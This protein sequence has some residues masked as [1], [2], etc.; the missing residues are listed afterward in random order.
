MS[1]P[2][3]SLY[4]NGEWVDTGENYEIRSPATEELVATVAKG[5]VAQ[6][7]QAVA[8]AKAAHEEGTWRRTP[9]AQRAALLNDVAGRLGGR[10]DELAA[11]QTRENGATIRITGALHI[12]LSIAQMQYLADQAAT[13]EFETAGPEIGPVPAEGLVRREPLGVVAAIVPWN[14]PLLVI[15]WK[16]APALAAGN[17]V[18]L[19]PDEHAPLVALELAKEFE[20]AG[21]PP[22]VLNVVT[23]DGEPTGAHLSG[24]PDVRKVAFTG[25]TAV[26][27]SILRQSADT[28]K[29]VTLELGGKGPNIILDSA[30]LDTAIDGSL[31][32]AL[33]NNGQACEA[34]TRL[35]IP[36]SKRDEIVSRLVERARTLKVGDPLDPATGVGPII[37]K[38]QHQRILDYFAIAETEGA[39]AVIGGGVPTGPGFDKGYWIEPTIFVGVTNDARIAREEVFGPVLVVLTY[40]SVEEAIKIANDTDYGLS[41]GVWGDEEQAIEIARELDAGMVWINDWHVIHPAYPFG[42]FKQ[43]GLGREGGPHALDEYTEAKFISLNRSPGPEARAF[44]IVIDPA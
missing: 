27:K 1:V 20:A 41:A 12:G 25:S 13:Y 16:I 38:V 18:V 29:R 11:L 9:P 15:V 17:T 3:Y 2:H 6:V 43:S 44:A 23:G 26:G 34:G 4:I 32:A 14:I 39:K 10:I 19:K 36:S 24:H 28:V 33:A 42:G 35:L 22:G 40:D 7:D 37:S 5:G 8:A 21:L 30:D 31:F